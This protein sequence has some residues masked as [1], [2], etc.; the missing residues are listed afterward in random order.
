M[1]TNT[2]SAAE[3]VNSL[4]GL[5]RDDHKAMLDVLHDYITTNHEDSGQESDDCDVTDSMEDER[6]DVQGKLLLKTM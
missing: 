5:S 1:S 4:L 6:P 2:T 3:A